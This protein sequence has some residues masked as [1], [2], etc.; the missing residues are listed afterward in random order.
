MSGPHQASTWYK[1]GIA[2]SQ[3]SLVGSLIPLSIPVL[4]PG[5]GLYMRPALVPTKTVSFFVH[6]ARITSQNALTSKKLVDCSLLPSDSPLSFPKSDEHAPVLS[7]ELSQPSSPTTTSQVI[8]GK[9]AAA[10]I[11]ERAPLERQRV[12]TAAANDEAL[13]METETIA[14]VS[15]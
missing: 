7:L 3:I 15:N 14:V 11:S 10:A 8:N 5:T 4:I 2:L 12:E 13:P 9:D 1:A 6:R